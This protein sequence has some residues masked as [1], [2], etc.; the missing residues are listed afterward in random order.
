MGVDASNGRARLGE[1][2]LVRRVFVR[3]IGLALLSMIVMALP[4][5]SDAHA[6]VRTPARADAEPFGWVVECAF[7]RHLT[8]D[9]IVYPGQPNQGHLHD[10]FGNL[11][12][13]AFSN[14]GSL[15]EATRLVRYPPI[16]GRI[17]CPPPTARPD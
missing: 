17:G 4:L 7:V 14:Y 11:T 6:S 12:T 15:I 5:R 1:P 8:A 3:S 16:P 9:P 2:S 13:D 10:F